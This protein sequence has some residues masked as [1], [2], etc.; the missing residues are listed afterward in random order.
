MMRKEVGK[1]KEISPLKRAFKLREI[2]KDFRGERLNLE[3]EN[4]RRVVGRVK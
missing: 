4:V 3:N 2:M 1:L